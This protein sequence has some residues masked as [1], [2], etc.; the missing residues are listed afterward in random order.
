MMSVG[1][2]IGSFLD[3]FFSRGVELELRG[4][5][6]VQGGLVAAENDATN[7]IDISMGPT[8]KGDADGLTLEPVASP[9]AAVTGTRARLRNVVSSILSESVA[10]IVV[11]RAGET[12]DVIL[13]SPRKRDG[14]VITAEISGSVVAPGNEL[15]VAPWVTLLELP[16]RSWPAGARFTGCLW[17]SDSGDPPIFLIGQYDGIG[18]GVIVTYFRPGETTLAITNGSVQFIVPGSGDLIHVQVKGLDED[19]SSYAWHGVITYHMPPSSL[20]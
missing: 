4:G 6:N 12:G 10:K 16:I 15:G 19:A 20:Y 14:G 13:T 7:V 3:R 2:Y 1:G 18:S 5:V 17:S 9:A 11:D 8:A